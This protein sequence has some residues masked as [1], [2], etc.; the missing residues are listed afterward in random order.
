ML[1]G[2]EKNMT[3]EILERYELNDIIIGIV[4]SANGYD[5]IYIRGNNTDYFM[6][7][8]PLVEAYAYI[9]GCLYTRVKLMESEV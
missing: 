5:V 4:K 2:N 9:A 8:V 1:K 7:N 3:G 6:K